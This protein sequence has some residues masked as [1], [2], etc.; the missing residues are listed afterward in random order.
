M[1]PPSGGVEPYPVTTTT[2]LMTTVSRLL[3]VVI[4]VLPPLCH[5]WH[6]AHFRCTMAVRCTRRFRPYQSNLI[7]TVGRHRFATG[8]HRHRYRTVTAR[9]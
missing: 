2:R 7:V 8:P 6:L 9:P 5:H 4:I 3:N 1:T